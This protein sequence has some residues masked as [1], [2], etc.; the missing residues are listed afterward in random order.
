MN[1]KNVHNIIEA[2]VPEDKQDSIKELANSRDPESVE[3][4]R[5]LLLEILEK[6][7]E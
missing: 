6:I 2:F 1:T 7:I 4:A 3:L 5:K